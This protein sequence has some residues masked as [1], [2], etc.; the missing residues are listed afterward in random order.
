MLPSS[1]YLQLGYFC[2]KCNSFIY[3]SPNGNTRGCENCV[4]T[5]KVVMPATI[6]AGNTVYN[7]PGRR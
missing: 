5:L 4:R 7:V 2:R 6:K 3:D 1:D